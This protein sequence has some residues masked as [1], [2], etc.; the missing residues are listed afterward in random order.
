MIA[1]GG[2]LG[3]VFRFGLS[4]YI[5]HLLD[6]SFPYGTLIVNMLGSFFIG[7]FFI[8]IIERGFLPLEWRSLIIIGFLGAFTT[9]STF[10]IETLVLIESGE[11]QRALLN[12]IFSV[13]ICIGATWVGLFFGRQL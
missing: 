5:Y 11:L 7:L 13:V 12:I 9:F 10:S 4:E 8:L 6:R 2:A 3:A 1:G